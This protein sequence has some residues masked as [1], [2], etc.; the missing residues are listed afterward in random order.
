[1][2]PTPGR[3]MTYCFRSVRLSHFVSASLLEY[4]STQSLQTSHGDCPYLEVELCQFLGQKFKLQGHSDVFRNKVNLKL[5]FGL[6]SFQEIDI[7]IAP[8]VKYRILLPCSSVR[9]SVCPSVTVCFRSI[10]RVPFE[11]EH[12]Y[13]TG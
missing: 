9:P 13:F 11:Q 2:P 1:M 8:M 12:L 3:H 5:F 10:T 7:Y 4:R 6:L